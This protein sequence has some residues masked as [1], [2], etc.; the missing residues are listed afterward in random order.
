MIIKWLVFGGILSSLVQSFIEQELLAQYFGPSLFG[1]CMTLVVTT[2]LEVCSEGASP[3][4]A[5]L[6]NKAGAPGNSFTFLMAGV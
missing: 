5:D 1:L 4:A 3:L 2:L 6:L